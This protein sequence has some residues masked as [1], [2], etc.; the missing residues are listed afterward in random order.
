MVVD[1][2]CSIGFPDHSAFQSGL[3][4]ESAFL[5]FHA[6]RFVSVMRDPMFIYM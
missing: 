5:V 1:A 3:F 4:S 2:V 6:V